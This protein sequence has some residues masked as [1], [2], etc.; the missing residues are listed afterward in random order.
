MYFPSS[1]WLTAQW[2]RERVGFKYV[3]LPESEIAGA[4]TILQQRWKP[5]LNPPKEPSMSPRFTQ[6]ELWKRFG[7]LPSSRISSLTGKSYHDIIHTNPTDR[8]YTIR[9]SSGNEIGVTLEDVYALYRELYT[10][11]KLTNGHMEQHCREILGWS[12]WH[13]PGSAMFA[14]LPLLDDHI[15]VKRGKLSV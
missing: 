12:S 13:A 6:D 3:E 9:Y 4:E 7:S 11:G 1:E 8:I 10:C 2:I 14:L 5:I 15:Q